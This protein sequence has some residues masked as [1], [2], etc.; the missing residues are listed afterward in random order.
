[1]LATVSRAG[2]RARSAGATLVELIITIVIMAIVLVTIA[3]T[4]SYSAGRSADLL[5]Q[6]KMVE[7]GQAYLEEILTKRF[8]ENSPAG[9][10]PA[11]APA[12]V[13]CGAVGVEGE[14]RILFDDVDDYN[15][16]NESP[17]L[18]P[19]GNVRQQYVGYRVVVA[20]SYV[21]PALQA[22]YGLDGVTDAKYI[23]VTVSAPTGNP[24]VFAAYKGNF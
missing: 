13:A 20:V 12:T 11:C 23:Q 15:G 24:L 17:P 21:T 22:A 16:L 7:L 1:M 19:D 4:L 9:G 5:F 10:V 6:V 8:D 14:T 2:C 18:D 3:S